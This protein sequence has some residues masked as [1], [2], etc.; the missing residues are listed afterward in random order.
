MV[1]KTL[2]S[3]QKAFLVGVAVEIQ[4]IDVRSIYHDD[5]D[6]DDGND[7]SFVYVGKLNI[8]I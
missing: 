2:K 5:D 7:E 6:D 1:Y 4:W 8:A 3:K